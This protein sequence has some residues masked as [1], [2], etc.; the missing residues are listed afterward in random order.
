MHII[1]SNSFK[2]IMKSVKNKKSL[3]SRLYKHIMYSVGKT[4]P[5]QWFKDFSAL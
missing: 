3:K 2:G 4:V 5:R 1:C